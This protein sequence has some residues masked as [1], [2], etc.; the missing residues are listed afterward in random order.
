MI[1]SIVDPSG[2]PAPLGV[3]GDLE[4]PLALDPGPPSA[5]LKTP[6]DFLVGEFYLAGSTP[7]DRDLGLIRESVLVGSGR[8]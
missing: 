4:H 6:S 1:F 7:V 5:A 2:R 3:L 8:S